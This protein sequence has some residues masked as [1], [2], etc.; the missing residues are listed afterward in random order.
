[1]GFNCDLWLLIEL[2]IKSC[3]A[4]KDYIE[5]RKKP[6]SIKLFFSPQVHSLQPTIFFLS[7]NWYQ[8]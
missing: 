4:C 8:S 5:L 2:P 6:L 1:M 7:T 3:I